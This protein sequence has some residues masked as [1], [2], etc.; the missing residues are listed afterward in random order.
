AG[1]AAR[2]RPVLVRHAGHQHEHMI[3]PI[4]Y[5]FVPVFFVL[6]G[7]QV[8]LRTL[9][10]PG[11][12]VVAL[13]LAAVAIVGKLAAGFFARREGAWIVGWGMVPRGEVGLIFAT[14]G[15]QLGVVDETMFSVIVV[16]VILTTLVTPPVLT[17]LLRRRD[18]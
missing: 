10:D 12:A 9:S 15:R 18:P 1:L 13:G 5:F 8:D 7:M 6:T 4:G 11:V 14:V 3:E 2:L 17:W 16:M